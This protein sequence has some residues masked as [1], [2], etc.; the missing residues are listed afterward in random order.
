VSEARASAAPAAAPRHAVCP[1]CGSTRLELF[2]EQEAIPVHSCRLVDTREEAEAFPR[3]TLRLAFCGACGFI[4]NTAYDSSLQSYFVSYEETQ[5]FSPRFQE[6]MRDLAARWIERYDL[7]GKDVLEIGCG[8][9][10]FLEAMCELGAAHGT[11][12]DPAIVLDRVTGPA[13]SRITFIQDLYDER[14]AHLTGDAVICRHTLEHIHPVAD[15][16]RLV[17]R[18]LE[19]RPLINDAGTAVLFE[20]PDVLRVLRECAFWDI[21]YEHC[22]YFT[23]GSLTR[24]FRATGFDVLALELDYDDQYILIE[25]RPGSG[26]GGEQP[27]LE[28]S[29]AEV[30]DAV[31]GFRRELARVQEHWRAELGAVRERGGRAVVWGSGSKGVAFLT[32][33]GVTD[34]VGY[35]V[36]INP[37][38]H[39]KFMAGTGHQIVPPS[40]LQDYRPDLVVAMNP[41]YRSEIQRDLD[42]LGVTARLEAV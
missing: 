33:L 20:L 12:I 2:H 21:Y 42:S 24:L 31:A 6:F 37:Y 10:E 38:K 1:A 14:Y 36:D 8:K 7:R 18:S 27:A 32:T 13:A 29:V 34:E 39:G 5:G 19:G 25:A 17:R 35:V 3:G 15:F 4:T 41:I 28:E 22:T 40:F 30:A 23:P 9:G 11:G 16:M 26:S